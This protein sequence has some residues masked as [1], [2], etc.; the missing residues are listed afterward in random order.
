VKWKQ[1][2]VRKIL[3]LDHCNLEGF[4]KVMLSLGIQEIELESFSELYEIYCISDDDLLNY[5]DFILN[6]FNPKN[7]EKLKA[8]PE[9]DISTMT[10]HPRSVSNFPHD[11]MKTILSKPIN[12]ELS[13]EENGNTKKKSFLSDHNQ[14][15]KLNYLNESSQTNQIKKPYYKNFI[16]SIKDNYRT[17]SNDKLVIL[18]MKKDLLSN[19]AQ[20]G[21]EEKTIEPIN[22]NTNTNNSPT[23]KEK[24]VEINIEV[25]SSV[26][27]ILD[28]NIIGISHN[29][30]INNSPV[31]LEKS[32]EPNS[33][34][35]NNARV[36]EDLD[37][38]EKFKHKIFKRGGSKSIMALSKQFRIFDKDK[39]GTIN[40]EEF[41]YLL[42]ALK[43]TLSD[44]ELKG[45]FRR[46]DNNEDDS[47]NYE[48][49]ISTIMG[50]LN[51][52]RKNLILK[53]FFKLDKKN[54][55]Y[56]NIENVRDIYDSTKHPDVVLN[57]KSSDHVLK[58][59]LESFDL[60]K[61]IYNKGKRRSVSCSKK[62]TKFTEKVITKDQFLDY[63]KHISCSIQ[64]DKYFEEMIN[65]SW[66]LFNDEEK[67]NVGKL[68]ERKGKWAH[69]YFFNKEPK[70]DT[71]NILNLIEKTSTSSKFRKVLAKEKMNSNITNKN[72]KA[73][74]NTADDKIEQP[75]K[76]LENKQE[77]I[78]KIKPNIKPIMTHIVEYGEKIN[79]KEIFAKFR[80]KLSQRGS[81]DIV[82]IS[83]A[84]RLCDS[85]KNSLIDGN[86]FERI[87]KDYQIGLNE[88]EISSLFRNFDKNGNGQISYDEFLKGLL[89]KMNAF[90]SNL[91]KKV[92]KKID[93]N[94]NQIIEISEI[95]K[96]YDVKYHPD[97]VSGK[98][99]ENTALSD[100]MDLFEDQFGVKFS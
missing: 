40:F 49:F 8:D 78:L 85:D 73:W 64:S 21:K 15:N 26:C 34:N 13:R 62:E 90:R 87:C 6:I 30:T 74:S 48:E 68:Y 23:K 50:D 19:C 16:K 79:L 11:H 29:N 43:I 1:I 18:G 7:I 95:K 65:N 97:V 47:V 77:S 86:E 69:E 93:Q 66:K 37:L 63:Y 36:K 99:D 39:S 72:I 52:F 42:N 17:S 10:V 38:F 75:G 27:P 61:S 51:N 67:P 33:D 24:S 57:K 4:K 58:D 9:L 91:V 14:I 56:I 96:L 94:D 76:F 98:I 35:I 82:G 71:V 84:F 5:K 83:R 25:N 32:I 92:F 89:G 44:D 31:K 54:N 41:Q 45:L 100:F 28:N 2:R 60:H 20:N 70:I 81:R 46:F 53:V 3:R 80:N 55:G 22:C 12:E 88:F 59:F